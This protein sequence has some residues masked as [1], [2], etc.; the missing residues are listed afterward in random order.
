MAKK[1]GRSKYTLIAVWFYMFSRSGKDNLFELAESIVQ[2]DMDISHNAL[3]AARRTLVAEGFLAKKRGGVKELTKWTVLYPTAHSSNLALNGQSSECADAS[4]S[5]HSDSHTVGYMSSTPSAYT[6]E[7]SED[8]SEQGSKEGREEAPHRASRSSVTEGEPQQNQNPSSSGSLADQD[9]EQPQTLHTYLPD[10]EAI[11]FKRTQKPFTPEEQR[12]ASA[13]CIEYGYKLVVAVLYNTLTQRPKSA[14]MRWTNFEV[15]FN[16]WAVNHDL[17]LAY[18]AAFNADRKNGYN[19]PVV[20]MFQPN[21]D[22]DGEQQRKLREY[23]KASNKDGDWNFTNEERDALGFDANDQMLVVRW[24]VENAI[25]VTK[26]RFIELLRKAA[27]KSSAGL[28][29]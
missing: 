29:G 9:Q 23:F 22:I 3:C 15:F 17:Y 1:H 14:K 7:T 6:S 16:N 21:D 18:V 19:L 13:L 5:D 27:G 26:K 10:V 20:G 24:C 8:T 4:M 28:C 2:W 25:R 11:W 12:M